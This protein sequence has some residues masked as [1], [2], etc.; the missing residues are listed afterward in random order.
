MEALD[1]TATLHAITVFLFADA[2]PPMLNATDGKQLNFR[3]A[4]L[5]DVGFMLP[6]FV[7]R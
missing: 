6:R 4:H 7:P 3:S 5:S 1:A 2:N